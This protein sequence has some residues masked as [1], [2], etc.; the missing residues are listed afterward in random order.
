VLPNRRFN[1]EGLLHMQSTSLYKPSP[2]PDGA[3]RVESVIR[4]LPHVIN[5]GVRRRSADE[6]R[7]AFGMAKDGNSLLM[8]FITTDGS[9]WQTLQSCPLPTPLKIGDRLKLELRI[10]GSQITGLWNGVAV[11]QA[12][13]QRLTAAGEWGLDVVDAS[14]KAVEVQPLPAAVSGIKLWDMPEKLPK[15]K[16]VSWENGAVRVDN[17]VIGTDSPAAR[18][19]VFRASMKFGTDNGGGAHLLVRHQEKKH[20]YALALNGKVIELRLTQGGNVRV[21]KSWP[22]PEKYQPDDW[23]RLEVRAIGPQLTVSVADQVLGTVEDS[24]LMAAGGV[25]VG[26]VRTGYFRDIEY[27]PLDAPAV[28]SSPNL[29]VSQSSSASVGIKLWDTPEK[30]PK[31]QGVS[32]ENGSLRLDNAALEYGDKKSRDAILRVSV[33]MSAD[34]AGGANILIRHHRTRSYYALTCVFDKDPAKPM[35]ELRTKD[36][37]PNYRVLASWPMPRA[38]RPDEWARFEFHAEGD[39]F[40]A[41]M[42]GETLGSFREATVQEPGGMGLSANRTAHFRDIEYVPL[43]AAVLSPSPSLPVSSSSVAT[44]TKD[45]PFTN[46]LG[47]KFVPVPITGG[48]TDKQRVLFSV[49]ETR[50]QDYELFVKETKHEWSKV[51]F[52]QGATHPAVFMSCVDAQAFCQWLTDRERKAGKLG[53]NEAYRLPSDH[54][55]SCAVGIGDKEDA[56]KLSSEKH[57]KISDVFPWGSVWPPPKGAGNYAGEEVRPFFEDAKRP[58]IWFKDVLTGYRD[59]FVETSPVGS[60]AA[61]RLGLFDMGG[62]VWEFCPDWCD[63]EHKAPALRGGSWGNRDRERLL[64]SA[65]PFAP[66]SGSRSDSHGF[67]CVLGP[68][69]STTAVSPAPNLPVSK[70]SDPKFPAGKWVKVFTKPEDLPADLSK[71]DRGVTW[72][73][74]WIKGDGRKLLQMI[75]AASNVGVRARVMRKV[76]GGDAKGGGVSG[77]TLRSDS[78]QRYQLK[79]LDDRMLGLRFVGQQST[80]TTV[81]ES[82]LPS[83]LLAGQEITLEF[84][85]VGNRLIARAGNSVLKLVSVADATSGSVFISGNDDLRDIEAINLDGLPEAEALRLLGVDEQ[86]NDLRGKT[87]AAEAWIDVLRDPSIV[88]LTKGAEI[89]PEGLRLPGGSGAYV[90]RG[91]SLRGDVAMRVR[92]TFGGARLQLRS[93]S[94]RRGFYALTVVDDKTISIQRFDLA[95]N[96]GISLRTFALTS[97]LKPGE[98]YEMEFRCVGPA[99]TASLNG[100]VLG[101]VSDGTHTEGGCVLSA[102]EASQTT[103]LAKAFSVL[104]LSKASAS[105]ASSPSSIHSFNGHRYQLISTPSTWAE[106]KARAEAMGGHLATFTAEA[107]ERWARE[108]LLQPLSAQESAATKAPDTFYWIGG[109]ADAQSKDFRWLSGEPLGKLA[110]RYGNPGWRERTDMPETKAVGTLFA[111]GLVV[112][113]P[114]PSGEWIAVQP[115]SLKRAGFIVEWDDAGAAAGTA[116]APPATAK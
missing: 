1:K 88:T 22:A 116:A 14:I 15:Q 58:W 4:Q 90:A 100:E 37:A 44:A 17:T 20:S 51:G 6:G 70:S 21:L 113:R 9:G 91:K 96:K 59:D 92:T 107:E 95:A 93:R 28:S 61:D 23:L 36:S 103:A 33:L 32:W 111:A 89:T 104:D 26:T 68:A 71:P 38:Y 101:T 98:D 35:V 31:Q 53:V 83:P 57:G 18:D 24:T 50:V 86:G 12:Q 99:L 46:T 66:N 102:W 87:G 60:F 3:I 19:L 108:T 43:D 81:L 29:P 25:S 79:L 64:S 52:N 13:D 11:L 40:T 110:W 80:G 75:T 114:P 56:A 69:P 94:D 78:S 85:T 76:T 62:N 105:A 55:W 106:A 72:E 2:F 82:P 54:E 30:L 67:R 41:L 84:A 65:R 74:G 5:L 73:D 16:G 42:D 45:A 63:K 48:P 77:I 115:Q 112:M 39:Q 97:P 49:W 34:N 109:H 7:Y 10:Q 8:R 27:V 47:M